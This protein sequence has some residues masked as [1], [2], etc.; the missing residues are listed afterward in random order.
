MSS[1][2][3]SSKVAVCLIVAP[4]YKV[5]YNSS[6]LVCIYTTHEGERDVMVIVVGNGHSKLGSNPEWD[7]CLHFT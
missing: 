4:P 1:S 6:I 7:C 3:P 2:S 5:C